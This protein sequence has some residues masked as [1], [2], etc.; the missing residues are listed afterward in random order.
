MIFLDEEKLF[1]IIE[2]EENIDIY[3]SQEYVLW[4]EFANVATN[5]LE[6]IEC[7]LDNMEPLEITSYSDDEDLC[8][9]EKIESTKNISSFSAW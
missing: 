3:S 1:G 8:I 7:F 4:D 2:G 5:L 9:P 6:K